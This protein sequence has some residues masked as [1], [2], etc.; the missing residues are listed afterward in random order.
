MAFSSKI[1]QYP[2]HLNPVFAR[3]GGGRTPRHA[4]IARHGAL[5][6]PVDNF[7]PGPPGGTSKVEI[8]LAERVSWRTEGQPVQPGAAIVA[9]RSPQDFRFPASIVQQ[10][11]DGFAVIG[12]GRSGGWLIWW[13][14]AAAVC[15][16]ITIRGYTGSPSRRFAS[17]ASTSDLASAGLGS[18]PRPGEVPGETPSGRW[19]SSGENGWT[20]RE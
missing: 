8:V 20:C 13:A 16:A 11:Q 18:P 10:P 9:T 17:M 12:D 4:D 5:V 2:H 15:P 3:T 7:P 6:V 19:I 1:D 14:M